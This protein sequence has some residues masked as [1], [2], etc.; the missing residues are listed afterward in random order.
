MLDTGI[1]L[2]GRGTLNINLDTRYLTSDKINYSPTLSPASYEIYQSMFY[3]FYR[4]YEVFC[5]CYN[6][7]SFAR[8]TTSFSH[9][10]SRKKCLMLA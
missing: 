6:W 8:D 2:L 1:D 7:R 5:A 3:D 9:G 10:N 4:S